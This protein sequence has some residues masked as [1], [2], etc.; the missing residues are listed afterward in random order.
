MRLEE[1]LLS[2]Q[3]ILA[4]R[5]KF[6]F[7][8]S[9]FP[10][11]DTP[12]INEPTGF[13]FSRDKYK[14]HIEF[15][16]ASASYRQMAFIAANRVG[17]SMTGATALV[18][19]LTGRYPH[20][21]EGKRFTR[22]ITAWMCGDNGEIVRDGI[23][24]AILERDCYPG[25]VG[26][27][28]LP[29]DCILS[30]KGMSNIPGAYGL[31]EIR[32]ISGG[33]STLAVKT[34]HKEREGFE[35]AKVDVVW[36]DEECPRAIYSECLLRT[37][38]TQGIVYLTFTPDKGLTDTVLSFFEDGTW[39]GVAANNKFVSVV[40]WED[41]PHLTKQMKEEM[42]EGLMPFERD[43]RSKGIPYLGSGVIYPISPDDITVEPFKIPDHFLRVYGLD[44]GWNRTAALW[45][46]IDPDT[47]VKYIYH[48]Y[49]VGEK[50]PSQHVYGIKAPGDWI[51]GVIDPAARGRGQADGHR[52]FE[53]Y[54]DLGLEL[55]KAENTVETGLY[56]VYQQLV[57]GQ[58][59][60]FS[61]C[62]NFFRE[63]RLYRRD[64]K[65]NV[66]KKNDHLLDALRYGIMSGVDIA[67]TKPTF[68]NNDNY[69]TYGV[70]SIGGY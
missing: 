61:T 23:Q 28:L 11:E 37:M 7:I 25:E 2:I 26:T 52:L 21:W 15:M 22:P 41:V 20:W 70:S 55:T 18:Y 3:S 43:C 64:D 17:K 16:N 6:N 34:Y 40:T 33:V 48:E 5:K 67:T 30:M 51:P 39:G 1:E 14:K 60:V 50:E 45:F 46:A 56:Q 35:S 47:R 66:I 13:I 9:V 32:H 63:F 57:S 42:L 29:K 54:E 8:D 68:T 65:G 59:K 31:Y 24:K 62:T 36:L 49:Y 38:T 58:L 19:H 27:G 4:D 12:D 53:M 10:D 44:V 69:D